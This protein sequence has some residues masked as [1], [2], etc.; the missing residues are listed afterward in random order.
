MS[1]PS[2]RRNLDQLGRQVGILLAE[3]ADIGRPALV[4]QRS[5][6][7]KRSRTMVIEPKEFLKDG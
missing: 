7:S 1:D 4:R 2:F 6:R 5:P 3:L